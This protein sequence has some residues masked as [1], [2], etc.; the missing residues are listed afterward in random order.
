MKETIL[1]LSTL[2]LATLFSGI[3]IFLSTVVRKVFNS[4]DIDV[5]HTFFSSIIRKG[6]KS[7]I[8]NVIVL[9][10]IVLFIIYLSAGFRNN[11]FI[12]GFSMYFIGSFLSSRFINEPN[13]EK[14]LNT[15]DLEEI[16]RLKRTLNIGNS[17]RAIV[18]F[19]GICLMSMSLIV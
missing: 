11:F 7:T 17:I 5:Y 18:S 16:E 10:P 4:V 3:V 2:L 8:I 6:R 12:S 15:T 1:I 19:L 9:V 13:Y 14:L